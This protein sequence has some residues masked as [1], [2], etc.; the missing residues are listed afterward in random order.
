MDQAFRDLDALMG[1]A[2]EMVALAE[3]FRE[4]MQG[5]PGAWRRLGRGERGHAGR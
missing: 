5:A 3:Y 2:R 1:K 4:R